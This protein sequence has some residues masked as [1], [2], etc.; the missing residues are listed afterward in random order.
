MSSKQYSPKNKTSSAAELWQLLQA[1]CQRIGSWMIYKSEFYLQRS[2]PAYKDQYAH[3]ARLYTYL[4]SEE[5]RDWLESH[6]TT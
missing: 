5:E 6:Y 3:K 2:E 1:L 4:P